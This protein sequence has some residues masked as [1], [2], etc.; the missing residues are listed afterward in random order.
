MAAEKIRFEALP[1]DKI[2]EKMSR[3]VT[4][5]HHMSVA[6]YAMKRGAVAP[7]HQH[8]NEQVTF[9]LEGRFR[10]TI[11]GK[12]VTLGP[13]ELVFIPPNAV[14]QG[15]A[16]EDVVCVDFSSPPRTDMQAGTDPL[17]KLAAGKS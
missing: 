1:E 12:E 14:H 5:G 4:L 11:D 17:K 10:Y 13:G 16:I 15:E 8:P 6:K 3:W 9:I 2:N 7:S